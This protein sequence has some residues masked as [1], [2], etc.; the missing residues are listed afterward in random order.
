MSRIIRYVDAAIEA[1]VTPGEI[2]HSLVTILEE[3]QDE[4]NARYLLEGL[5][6]F[7][8]DR[9]RSWLKNHAAAAWEPCVR[10]GELFTA[11]RSDARY[12]STRCRVAAKRLRDTAPAASVTV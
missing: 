8:A 11:S 12:C 9:L 5:R 4:R 3:R 6:G 10:C 7:Q 1:G 2:V